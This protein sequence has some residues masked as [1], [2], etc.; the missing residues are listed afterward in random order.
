MNR[1]VF[2]VFIPIVLVLSVGSGEVLMSNWKIVVPELAQNMVLNPSA[3]I[4]GNFAAVGGS[5]AQSTTYSHYG[6]YSYWVQ[7]SGDN[8]GMT[9]ALS[10]LSNAVHYVTLRVRGTLPSAWDWSLDN[11]N[12]TTPSLIMEMDENWSLY[13][14]SFV[15]AQ[16]N[17]ST[18][19]YIYQDGA[20][21]GSFYIDGVQV[22]AAA[23]WTTYVD[24]TQEGCAWD[25]SEHGSSSTRSVYSRA[26][27]RV[28]DLKDDYYFGVASEAGAGVTP[29]ALRVNGYANLPGGQLDNIQYPA[30]PFMLSGPLRATGSGCSLHTVRRNLEDILLPSAYPKLNDEYQAVRIWYTG[31]AV[32]KQ[33]SAHYESGLQGNVEPDNIVMEDVG[34]RFVANDPYWYEIGESSKVLTLET[35]ESTNKV[36][37]R[38]VNESCPYPERWYGLGAPADAEAGTTMFYDMLIA[39]DHR[40]YVVGNFTNLDGD[41]DADRIGRYTPLTD[42]WDWDA[43]DGI[44]NGTAYAIVLGADGDSLYAGGTFTGAGAQANTD[45][46]ALY[47]I[48]TST[49]SALGTGVSATVDV[50]GLAFDLAGNLYA[51]GA[52]TGMGGVANTAR[53]AMWDG[54]AWNAVGSGIDDGTVYAVAVDSQNNIYFAGSFTSVNGGTAAAGI[55]KYDGSTW[56]ALGTGLNDT[57]YSLAID[58]NDD[59][60]VGGNFTTAGGETANY[61][62]RWN[63]S[64]WLSVGTN[65]LLNDIVW[66]MQF[67]PDRLLW[68]VGAFDV[69]YDIYGGI[70]LS[71]GVLIWNGAS[72]VFPGIDLSSVGFSVALGEASRRDDNYDVYLG[73]SVTGGA[74]TRYHAGKDTVTNEGSVPAYP[75]F[76]VARSGATPAYMRTLRNVSTGKTIWMTYALQNG[77]TIT[78]D[79][80]PKSKDII[81][82]FYGRRFDAVLPG[83]TLGQ[84]SLMPGD[85]IINSFVYQSAGAVAS[86]YL[87]WKDTYAGYD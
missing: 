46:V 36:I 15:A 20:G 18:T 2:R 30:R 42:T 38:L 59:V 79:L 69:Y 35:G 21:A 50:R 33:I 58:T 60:Y 56:T 5:A 67:G 13:G 31:G 1:V 25:Q 80:E 7:T 83:S 9:L 11:A 3:E 52:F 6:L 34:L 87:I 16:A 32:V 12:W 86:G 28:M 68:A 40:L 82:S 43:G 63:G 41:A 66:K 74:G 51:V 49:W 71:T 26:G 37:G 39:P 73:W 55:V 48:S 23:Y 8:E 27:G 77:E 54:A 4:A 44:D 29:H 61:I 70:T 24:G 17:A 10:A 22:E 85:N 72:W 57:A 64:R 78:I 47:T 45:G 75:R 19:L 14:A 84:W 76:I 81:S 65:D 53:V 62:A